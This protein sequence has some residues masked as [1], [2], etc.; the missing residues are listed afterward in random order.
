M[1]S[2]KGA[3]PVVNIL[4]S[5]L[6]LSGLRVTSGKIKTIVILCRVL[7]SLYRSQGPKGAALHLKAASVALQQSLG[8]YL[9]DDIGR[10]SGC[11]PSRNRSGFPR[12]ILAQHRIDIRAGESDIV[13]FYLTFFN[14]YR[15]LLYVGTPGLKSI[16]EPDSGSHAVDVALIGFL[17][18][19]MQR[20]VWD[21]MSRE[22][23]LTFMRAE[24]GRMFPL[25][26]SSPGGFLLQ[27][28]DETE[29]FNFS[30]HPAVLVRQACA[31]ASAPG[32]LGTSLMAVLG[33]FAA[34]PVM[35][36][37][38]AI[39]KSGVGLILPPLPALGK[40][41]AKVEAAGKVRIF[42]MVD[43][44]TQWALRP[45]HLG[46]F[47]ILKGIPMDGTFEQ[48]APLYRADSFRG[49][50]SLDLTAA[51]DR[52]PVSLQV[53][54]LGELLGDPAVA[55]HWANLLVNRSYRFRVMGFS[56]YHGDY[57][58]AVGQPMGAL[59][60]WAMLAF[61]HHYLVQASAW[62]SGYPQHL[63]YRDYAILG[64]DLVLGDANVKDAYLAICDSIGVK[65]GLHKSILSPQGTAL[66]FAK[67]TVWNGVDVSPV[68]LK[69]FNAA[70]QTLPSLVSFAAKYRLDLVR[71][72]RVFGFGWRTLTW[73]N[74]PLGKLSS[75]VRLI[76]L[77]LSLPTD[78]ASA[79]EFF[80]RGEPRLVRH[81]IDMEAVLQAFS[82]VELLRIR[83][84]VRLYLD[85]LSRV[86][87]ATWAGHCTDAVRRFVQSSLPDP[88]RGPIGRSALER[89]NRVSLFDWY[90]LWGVLIELIDAVWQPSFRELWSKVVDL[91]GRIPH[92]GGIDDPFVLYFKY[93]T[94]LREWSSVSRTP[95]SQIRPGV[96]GAEAH[97][98][99]RPLPP[100]QIRLWKKWSGVVQGSQSLDSLASG[101]KAPRRPAGARRKAR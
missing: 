38:L 29:A 82:K 16:V 30:S 59:S 63:L 34:A 87:S 95:F 83:G 58:Y 4:K 14:L 52:L 77:G 40:L 69:E 93:I 9:V 42:A 55:R 3:R 17:P 31:L 51:T 61:T 45:V 73:L 65:V 10:I 21:R 44:W 92:T 101:A 36:Q 26:R 53:A 20:F 41:G 86:N 70:S 74:R 35:K 39:V 12:L 11:R 96:E 19:F 25:F 89:L 5:M 27:R 98:S 18:S 81:K 100:V 56:Q 13:R 67:R 68:P 85:W 23:L 2:V 84:Q 15:N 64:D 76:I 80:R 24:A 37:F 7:N 60:S 88:S 50:Y 94:F 46:V 62:M 33:F 97:G 78:A 54:L 99:R 79:E 91:Q 90:V 6:I 43:A 72:L 48:S 75:S 28:G 66:E 22:H 32:G 49:L 8:G 1:C 57:R 71:T 47:E